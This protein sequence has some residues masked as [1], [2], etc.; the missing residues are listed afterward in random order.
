VPS[1]SASGHGQ[2]PELFSRDEDI[3]RV[4]A[5]TK[6]GYVVSGRPEDVLRIKK[7]S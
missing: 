5:E 1:V 3:Q 4:A 6:G 7:N 2:T